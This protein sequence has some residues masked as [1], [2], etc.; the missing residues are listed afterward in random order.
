MQGSAQAVSIGGEPSPP[1]RC[2]RRA[3]P[4]QS[5]TT[6]RCPPRSPDAGSPLTSPFGVLLFSA[7]SRAT[8]RLTGPPR[9]PFLAALSLTLSHSRSRFRVSAP[10]VNPGSELR[11]ARPPLGLWAAW[12]STLVELRAREPPSPCTWG[13]VIV[14]TRTPCTSRDANIAHQPPPWPPLSI[15]RLLPA[16]LTC[17]LFG[18]RGKCE[19][20]GASHASPNRSIYR[21]VCSLRTKSI[22]ARP[23]LAVC[24]SVATCRETQTT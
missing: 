15:Q 16:T 7:A 6:L 9:R 11:E 5:S 2:C 17:P 8:A 20:K 10:R 12:W 14:R 18:P 19:G 1:G 24:R 23:C 3:K 22:R 4:G 21:R 13:P